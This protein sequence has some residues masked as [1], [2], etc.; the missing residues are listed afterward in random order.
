MKFV[1]RF[2]KFIIAGALGL[3]L[4]LPAGAA[5]A[6]TAGTSNVLN[7]STGGALTQTQ[8]AALLKANTSAPS[9]ASTSTFALD[10]FK[11][12]NQQRK[13]A[14]LKPILFNKKLSSIA[15]IK[16]KDLKV[17]KYFSHT[18]PKLGTPFQLLKSKGVKYR[19]AGEN[20]AMGQRTPS[21]VMKDWMNSKGH[22]AN[23]LN[24]NY[25]YI[26]IAYYQG[27]WVQL[28]TG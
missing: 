22:K 9:A 25:K 3:T 7:I 17:N 10:V 16:A 26:G 4:A 1:A 12:V 14:G 5:S 24:K 19:Y 15:M 13:K 27:E 8:L 2:S 11:I 28:F 6:A 21:Q 18:S 23:I 20:I